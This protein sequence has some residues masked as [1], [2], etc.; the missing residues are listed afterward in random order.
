MKPF[1]SLLTLVLFSLSLTAQTVPGKGGRKKQG[2]PNP[3][4]E[5]TGQ[6]EP[7]TQSTGTP[8][9]RTKNGATSPANRT[10]QPAA[11]AVG[12]PVTG[13]Q[14]AKLN[15]EVLARDV[16][17]KNGK[18]NISFGRAIPARNDIKTKSSPAEGALCL[19]REEVK[20]QRVESELV[21]ADGA[22]ALALLPGGVIDANRLLNTGE[23]IYVGM[24]NR[25]PVALSTTS[26]LVRQ[27]SATVQPGKNNNSIEEELRTKV[28]SLTR[29]S[30]LNGMPN[31][32]SSSEVSISTLQET[33]GVNIG[34]S[35][36]YMGVSAESNFKFSSK[37]YRYMYVYQFEQEC[38]PVLANAIT[39]PEDVFRDNPQNNNNWL[40]VREVKYG[41]R[42]YVLME[43]EYDLKKY[44]A[45]LNGSLEWGVVSANLKTKTKGSSLS[46]KTNI[47]VLT[48]GGTFVSITDPANIQRELDKY[49][50]APF[51]QMDIVPL[52]YKLTYLDG[53]PVSMVTQAFLDGK[54]C[55]A[56]NRVRV[57][58]SKIEC[59]KA[60][61]NKQNE[62]V[63]GSATIQL[64]NSAGQE[65]MGDGKTPAPPMA[66]AGSFSYGSKDA[67]LVIT[68][69]P[70]KGK[71]FDL[72]QQGKY[73]DFLIQDLDTK[74]EIKPVLKEKDNGFNADDD[75]ITQD[76]LKK[77]LRQMLLEGST[78]PVFE[79]RFKNAVILIYFE[80]IPMP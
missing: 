39:S 52:S 70:G 6:A 41:R 19:T 71:T 7:A 24:D 48:Q 34:G 68:E 16:S 62:E 66:V 79:F 64:F 1:I 60:D 59:Q 29:P 2:N 28:Q 10:S 49:F 32:R 74:L 47:R 45:E 31:V 50:A 35:F 14:T 72:N 42:L 8:K 73:F 63:Y 3:G 27:V 20:G 58:I 38:L 55:L 21:I 53:T 4:T 44:A 22:R 9:S 54:N 12:A 11:A 18:V 75:F 69:G 43:S 30:N 25:K 36:F 77:S 40:Y 15:F 57:R 46:E 80:I 17:S 65:V 5:Q 67:P 33:I 76:R 37:Q 26:N 51:K 78:S 56:N 23:F 61:D 13:S